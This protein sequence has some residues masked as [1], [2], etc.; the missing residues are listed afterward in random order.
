M[1]AQRGSLS[2]SGQKIM[3]RALM[4][5]FAAI[6]L[7]LNLAT[8]AAAAS[9]EDAVAAYRKGDY[10]NAL[11][12]YRP[13]AEQG[14]AVAQF[15]VGLMYDMGQGVLQNYS[16]AVKWY[17]LAADQNHKDAIPNRDKAVLVMTP[18]QVAEA[19]KLAG[20]WKLPRS[21]PDHAPAR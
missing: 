16:E 6:I 19:R 20:Q 21:G 13:L 2:T 18:D 11:Q 17:R 10:T 14:L 3:T 1:I 9:L 8:P 4:G 12:L 7:M 5:I 15:N